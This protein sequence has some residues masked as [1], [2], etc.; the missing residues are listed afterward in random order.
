MWL[1]RSF[2]LPLPASPSST[3]EVETVH[4]QVVDQAHV[5]SDL[6]LSRKEAFP[7]FIC[8]H[9]LQRITSAKYSGP[10]ARLICEMALA[11][12]QSTLY[13][14]EFPLRNR[15]KDN[16]QSIPRRVSLFA[17]ILHRERASNISPR[18]TFLKRLSLIMRFLSSSQR[19]LNFNFPIVEVKR[20][21]HKRN[22]TFLYS[23]K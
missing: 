9:S 11:A 14:I 10:L 2:R 12:H 21:R 1:K 13:S 15:G 22:A 23:P 17:A 7:L 5:A 16:S 4:P 19:Q 20:E 8:I 3:N 18:F 6:Q